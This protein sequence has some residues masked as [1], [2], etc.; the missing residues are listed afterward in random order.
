VGFRLLN[1]AEKLNK[2]I[3]SSRNKNMKFA[4]LPRVKLTYRYLFSFFLLTLSTL[5]LAVV[6]QTAQAQQ[7]PLSLA[8]ILIGLRSKKVILYERNRLLTDAVKQRGI[9]FAL[10]PEI[11][12]ELVS[13]GADKE[14]I[15]A[16]RQK[17]P[18][19]QATP[20]PL[21]KPLPTPVAT[22]IPVPA[23][24]PTPVPSPPAPD[25]AFY[26][27]RADENVGRGEYALAVND[28]SR[29]IELNPKEVSVYLNR[30]LAHY[31]Q[32]NYDLAA[33]DYDK[34][35]ELNPGDSMLYFNR[36]NSYEKMGNLQ[37]ALVDYR[38]AFE[39]DAGNEAAKLSLQ[40]LQT[41]E[42]KILP[43]PNAAE[44]TLV[45]EPSKTPPGVELGALIDRAVRLIKPVY[46]PNAQKMN[47]EGQVTVQVTLDEEGNVV[48][49]KATAGPPLLRTTCEDAARKSKFKPATV[50]NQAVK[51]TG[52]ISYNFK[53]AN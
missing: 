6:L 45:S 9:T 21:P 10:T 11:E 50:G 44:K 42:A 34:A 22:P 41:A 17:S 39:L 18:V 36:G 40:R 3:D 27:K 47:I 37:K 32:K 7:V 53:A 20:S 5:S 26:R 13:T 4:S 35:I 30:G 23:A 38:K 16:I 25:F 29:A 24:T 49:A 8:D 14:L 15:E 52:F 31:N 48:T 1:F 43:K 28:Y 19:V 51:A 33:S 2:S 46:P 12:K